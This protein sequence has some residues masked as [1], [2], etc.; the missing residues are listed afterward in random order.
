MKVLCK[1]YTNNIRLAS[2]VSSFSTEPSFRFFCLEGN[3]V[4]TRSGFKILSDIVTVFVSCIS[5]QSKNSLSVVLTSNPKYISLDKQVTDFNT[6]EFKKIY[7]PLV[8]FLKQKYEITSNMFTIDFSNKSGVASIHPEKSEDGKVTL[9]CTLKYPEG[10]VIVS[11][12]RAIE[13]VLSE[14]VNMRKFSYSSVTPELDKEV[15]VKKPR[16]E[17]FK[18]I[19]RYLNRTIV[20]ASNLDEDIFLEQYIS[21]SRVL[22]VFYKEDG[23]RWYE[24][25]AHSA[26]KSSNPF[27]VYLSMSS[28]DDIMREQGRNLKK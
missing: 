26:L 12:D 3:L 7:Y 17:L 4:K 23:T 14:C 1:Y 27:C 22:E 5:S 10:E 16:G 13:E 21:S 28:V 11:G 19:A 9:A 15:I 6:F 18:E 25:I 8:G 20:L 2:G 24:K